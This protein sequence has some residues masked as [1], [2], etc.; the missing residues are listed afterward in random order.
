MAYCPT[1]RSGQTLGKW[2]IVLTI[3]IIMLWGPFGWL[4][5]VHDDPAYVRSWMRIGPLLPGLVPTHLAAG[6]IQH[7]PF[8][9]AITF[10][11]MGAISL[12]ALTAFAW[13]GTRNRLSL[14]ITAIVSLMLSSLNALIAYRLFAA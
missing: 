14:I 4:V 2:L 11:V 3:M 5:F 13:L 10:M 1:T 6:I 7:R 9:D 8:N 12:G